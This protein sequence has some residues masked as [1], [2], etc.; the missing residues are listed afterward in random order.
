MKMTNSWAR[1][2]RAFVDCVVFTCLSRTFLPGSVSGFQ[3]PWLFNYVQL[4]GIQPMFH[5]SNAVNFYFNS[6]FPN[7]KCLAYPTSNIKKNTI[8]LSFLHPWAQPNFGDCLAHGRYS[9][10]MNSS[11]KWQRSLLLLPHFQSESIFCMPSVYQELWVLVLGPLWCIY[12]WYWQM[13]WRFYVCHKVYA[14]N[15][16]LRIMATGF[17]RKQYL[18]SIRDYINVW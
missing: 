9:T 8:S 7:S 4:C 6:R 10:S 15:F 17:T 5:V 13:I 18:L 11:L 16:L 12:P 14:N 3:M 1:C 2:G